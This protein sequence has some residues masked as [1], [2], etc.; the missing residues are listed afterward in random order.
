MTKTTRAADLLGKELLPL[1][2]TAKIATTG[3]DGVA[4]IVR[5]PDKADSECLDFPQRARAAYAGA[6]FSH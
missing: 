1:R 6:S 5:V 2:V 3:G 4:A